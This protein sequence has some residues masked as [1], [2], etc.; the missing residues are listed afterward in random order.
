[1]NYIMFEPDDVLTC[2]CGNT[3]G[4]ILGFEPCDKNGVSIPTD[5]KWLG[6]FICRK[7]GQIYE[8]KQNWDE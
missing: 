5:N 7:C 4:N 3:E 8:M 6:H 2:K 1:M